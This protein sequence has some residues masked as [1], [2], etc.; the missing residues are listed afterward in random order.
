MEAGLNRRILHLNSETIFGF[1][2][3]KLDLPSEG[4]SNYYCHD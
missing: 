2:K 3:Q 1:A 4:N